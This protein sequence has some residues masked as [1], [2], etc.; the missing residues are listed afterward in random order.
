MGLGLGKL[1]GTGVTELV[2]SVGKVLDDVITNK[3]EKAKLNI[4]LQTLI[5]NHDEKMLELAQQE[6]DSYLKDTQSA[7]EMNS[8]IQ[9]SDKA[10]WLA[11]N[12]MYMLGGII[13]LGFLGLLIYMTK[14]EIPGTNKDI[15]NILI[16]VLGASFTQI[17][18]FLF[19]SSIG[20]Q[21][22]DQTIK[23]MSK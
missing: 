20:S 14:Y 2:G 19:G 11:K 15:L 17:V 4:E 3:E 12:F 5:F 18:Q 1:F 22:K 10:S 8:T 7:R 23:N 16:G 6:V 21:N 9:A 13:V